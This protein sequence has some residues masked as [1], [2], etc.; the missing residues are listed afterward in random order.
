M[1]RTIAG[2]LDEVPR[3]PA[4]RRRDRRQ[5]LRLRP[6]VGRRRG[7]RRWRSCRGA[8]EYQGQK[9]SA[10]SRAYVPRSLW[11]A[12]KERLVAEVVGAGAWAT[13]GLPHL[14][15]RGHRPERLR[16]HQAATSTSPAARP[17]ARSSRAAPATTRP[18]GSSP[19][20]GRDQEP[21]LPA[22]AG[23]DLR[24][25]ADGLRLRRR[26]A[27]RGA[28]DLRRHL[29]LRAHRRGLRPGPRRHRPLARRWR[30]PPATST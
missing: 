6:P 19:H 4:H 29:A 14:P 3:L 10:A 28:R 24:A 27:R 21:A 22:H 5:G 9:C 15:R 8:F 2:N 30:T 1:W 7:A 20:G 25:G 18:A 12:L 11:P 17:G 23:G 26:P 13:R 16:P